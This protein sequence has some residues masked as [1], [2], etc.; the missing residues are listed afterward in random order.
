MFDVVGDT[1]R[2]KW[3][4]Q[5]VTGQIHA[6][7]PTHSGN[8]DDKEHKIF[9]I[10]IQ[11]QYKSRKKQNQPVNSRIQ[12]RKEV[13]RLLSLRKS[14]MNTSLTIGKNSLLKRKNKRMQKRKS[15]EMEGQDQEIEIKQKKRLSWKSC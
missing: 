15:L 3:V 4:L 1:L 9:K 2:R 8:E 14:M 10:I 5:L 13:T 6:L 11:H 7:E 12:K